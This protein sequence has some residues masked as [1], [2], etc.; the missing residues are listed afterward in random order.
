MFFGFVVNDLGR[1]MRFRTVQIFGKLHKSAAVEPIFEI[2]GIVIVKPRNVSVIITGVG[3]IVQHKGI[4]TLDR[5]LSPT[6][7]LVVVFRF[8]Q[9]V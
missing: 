2:F 7:K 5:N 1:P 3:G 4:C 6:P 8:I 9:V